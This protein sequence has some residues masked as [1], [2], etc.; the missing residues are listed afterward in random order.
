MA[1]YV[2][3]LLACFLYLTTA[4]PHGAPEGACGTFRPNHVD[5]STGRP[6]QAKNE[7]DNGEPD[8]SECPYEVVYSNKF[9]PGQPLNCKYSLKLF[10]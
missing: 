4:Y 6:H 2:V 5:R 3:T 7:N 9:V 1:I 8:D 10:L